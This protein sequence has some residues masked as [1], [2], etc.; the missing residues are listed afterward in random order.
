LLLVADN[1]PLPSVKSW[2]AGRLAIFYHK[3]ASKSSS[4][5]TL[6]KV[7]ELDFA[8]VLFPIVPVQQHR[9]RI[10]KGRVAAIDLRIGLRML[11][12]EGRKLL[13][14]YITIKLQQASKNTAQQ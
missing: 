7:K 6:A 5:P 12:Q 13:A 8:R 1:T 9:E 14:E 4:C 11:G 10:P 2:L 3:I